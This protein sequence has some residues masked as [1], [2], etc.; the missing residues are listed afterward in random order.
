MPSPPTRYVL[1]AVAAAA[2]L[3]IMVSFANAHRAASTPIVI[4]NPGG[5]TTSAMVLPA[6]PAPK[7]APIGSAADAA[8]A[9]GTAALGSVPAPAALATPA[10]TPKAGELIYVHVAGAVRHPSLYQLAPS[11]RVWHAIKAAGG[12]SADADENAVNLAAKIHDGEKIYVPSKAK[13]ALAAAAPQQAAFVPA[14]M[15]APVGVKT[16]HAPA[17]AKG[18]KGAGAAGAGK[19]TKLV[20]A[21]QGQVNINTAGA[22]QLQELPGVGPAMAA[23]ILAYRQQAGGFQK[24]EDLMSV[25]GIGP[26][27][28]ARIAPL[29]KLH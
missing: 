27:K 19:P 23:R 6:A 2:L 12:P 8:P 5:A 18:G 24:P 16:A 1:F 10:P 9:P 22:E 28:F 29:I 15:S 25:G 3:A 14:P 7:A 17:L 26:K 20:S 21:A 4:T 13:S 11:S